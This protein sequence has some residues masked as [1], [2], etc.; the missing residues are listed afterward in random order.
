MKR[1]HALISVLLL[2]PGPAAGEGTLKLDLERTVAL[3]RQ[4]SPL[5]RAARQRIGEAR[6]NL[7]AAS[8]LLR[9]N[10]IASITYG[11]RDGQDGVPDQNDS[12]V[13]ISQE[14]EVGGQRRARIASASAGVEAAEGSAADVER[15]ILAAVSAAF[16]DALLAAER[17]RLAEENSNLVR[18][19]LEIS[20]VR[21]EKGASPPLELNASRIRVALSRGQEEAARSDRTRATVVLLTL[22]GLDA[23]SEVELESVIPAALDVPDIGTLLARARS[24]PDILAA[25]AVVRS[26]EANVRLADADRVPSPIVGGT[27]AEDEGDTIVSGTL[28]IGLPLFQRNQGERQRARAALDRS[29]DELAA[30]QIEVEREIRELFSK[31]SAARQILSYYDEDVVNAMD[32]NLALLRIMFEAGKVGYTEVALLQRE[33]IETSLA[34]ARARAEVAT[35][36]VGLRAAAG[37]PLTNDVPGGIR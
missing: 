23:G 16:F 9:S 5:I 20:A 27:V 6:G 30:L 1:V 31:Y 12:E 24:R 7:T 14:L 36:V 3:A 2:A 10:P 8:V 33:R 32:E 13:T 37:I 17:L 29:R 35:A 34:L 19:L 22:V 11:Q 4:N 18:E 21:V 26:A 25:Q 28:A 15:T